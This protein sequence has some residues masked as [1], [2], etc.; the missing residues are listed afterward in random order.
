MVAAA[1]LCSCVPTG[2]PSAALARSPH[3]KSITIVY[4]FHERNCQ[5]IQKALDQIRRQYGTYNVKL[6]KIGEEKLDYET[7][8]RMKL[9][10]DSP[11]RA[12]VVP[13][14]QFYK[15][16]LFDRSIEGGS[17]TNEGVLKMVKEYFA[18][19]QPS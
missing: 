15:D 18:S 7:L 8:S 19:D 10:P 9:V 2:A 11:V 5:D 13:S 6:V 12:L 1:L 3:K 16:G 14:F 4:D 17:Y